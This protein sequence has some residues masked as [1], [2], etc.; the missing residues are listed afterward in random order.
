M[1]TEDVNK[2]LSWRAAV[3]EFDTSKKLGDAQVDQLLEAVNLAPS[4][5]GLQPYHFYVVSDAGVK[6]KI[7]KAGYGQPQFT[8]ASHLIVFASDVHTTE[9]D[10]D[11]YVANIAKTRGVDVTDLE[12]YAQMMKGSIT[13]KTAADLE[14]WAA[15]QVYIPV[16]VL[17]AAAS[18]AGIDSSPMEGFDADEVSN[19]VGATEKG[20]KARVVVALGYRSEDDK[21]GK[22][23]KVRRSLGE[24][25]TKI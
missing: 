8:S 5:Y 19:I 10:V 3:K 13:A 21:Y 11:A 14:N 15:Q 1:T 16:G 22:M 20:F 2:A 9:Q 17:M 23:K 4:S 25:V 6:E 18:V 7:G 24:I 12:E